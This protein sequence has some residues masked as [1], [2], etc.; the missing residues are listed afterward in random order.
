MTSATNSGVYL[1]TN[2]KTREQNI[3]YEHHRL[4]MIK[5]HRSLQ[6]DDIVPL[7]RLWLG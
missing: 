2:H 7:M 5:L 1:F 3:S 4:E 6:F